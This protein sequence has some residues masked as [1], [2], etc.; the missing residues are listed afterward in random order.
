[1]FSDR[2]T[3]YPCP[4]AFATHM[5]R[6]GA[7]FGLNRVLITVELRLSEVTL[8]E[9]LGLELGVDLEDADY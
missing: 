5:T 6:F 4:V 2:M 8:A 3:R 7:C 1:M 9:A